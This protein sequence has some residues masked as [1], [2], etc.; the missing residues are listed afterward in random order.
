MKHLVYIMALLTLFGC[1]SF[2]EYAPEKY[3]AEGDELMFANA[4]YHGN[5]KKIKRLLSDNAIDV[6]A[7]GKYGF[8]YLMY[9]IYIQQYGAARLLLENGADPNLLSYV[10]HPMKGNNPDYIKREGGTFR[11]MPLSFVCGHPDWDIKYIKLLIE[12]GADV[13][14]TIPFSPIHELIVGGASD[15]KRIKYLMEHGLDLNVPDNSGDT[16]VITAA[17]VRELDLVEYF[18]DNGASPRQ[19]NKDG[20]SLGY[21]LQQQIERNLGTPEYIA[22][23]R[24][25]I[26]RLKGMGVKFPVTKKQRIDEDSTSIS[27]NTNVSQ[28]E[29]N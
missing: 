3:F 24:A 11:L 22:H 18:L 1:N 16:P 9:A 21:E 26:E 4:I 8:T 6:N 12:Y 23:A 15:M 13:N 28:S 14:A 27:N 10:N 5:S 17:I 19:I 29:T 20:V 25:I 2:S 7:P